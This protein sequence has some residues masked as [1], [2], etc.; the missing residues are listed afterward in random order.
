MGKSCS[1]YGGMR[2]VYRIL[3]GEPERKKPRGNPRC[4][5]EE[6]IVIDL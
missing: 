5:W 2:N 3:V 6:N 1:P 4:R